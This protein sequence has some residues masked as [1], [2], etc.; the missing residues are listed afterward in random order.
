MNGRSIS[1]KEFLKAGGGALA[2][3][4]VVGLAGC[5]GG[6]SSGGSSGGGGG[7][8]AGKTLTYWASNQATSI[9]GDKQVLG[10][11]I[12]EFKKKTG[13]QVN[14]QVIG[15][16][17]LFNKITTAI[18]SGQGPD[19]LNIGN[20]WSP[21]F[22][23]TGA[24][25][26]FDQGA[27]GAIGG[28]D[29]FIETAYRT[30]GMH[31]PYPSVPLY[32]LA[33]GLFYNKAMFEQ[34]GIKSP[35][36]TWDEFVAVAR[37]LTKPPKQWGF[38]VEGAS[39]TENAHWA[40]MLGKQQGGSLFKGTKP[41]FDSPGVVRGVAQYIGFMDKDRIVAP[42]DAQ[43]S[44]GT[45]S[46]ADFAKGKAAMVIGQKN[47]MINFKSYG[48]KESEY[49]VSHMPIPKQL[50]PGGKPIMSHTAGINISIFK[51][52]QNKKG[53]LE[54]VK[55]MTS[56]KMQ[57]Y[58]NQQYGSLP[59]TKEAS[60]AQVF[61]TPVMKVFLD[62]Y[63]NHSAP[64]PLVPDEGQMETLVGGAVKT[65]FGKAATG[66]VGTSDVKSQLAAANQKMAAGGGA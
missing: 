2:G 41:T 28:K 31:E 40:F 23:Q 6:Q 19:V 57:V 50:P 46:P 4:S 53:A 17:D 60:K 54:F 43:Y 65:L 14:L 32:G 34:A 58:L 25:L 22:Q 64:M 12:R 24:F 1:R 39:I 26:P 13:I 30:S 47:Y 3:A 55:F 8:K 16:P 42:Q 49:G 61:Q 63:A 10:R 15:W 35:P 20:T 52:T 18:S 37:K 62:V 29:K 11:V 5:G 21:T 45:Q 66:R 9:Q 56:K 38:A 7:G 36:K 33:Y 51:N 44:T 59:V 27:L 48:M